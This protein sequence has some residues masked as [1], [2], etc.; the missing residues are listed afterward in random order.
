[1]QKLDV[2]E[3]KVI[4]FDFHNDPAKSGYYTFLIGKQRDEAFIVLLTCG[5]EVSAAA[6]AAQ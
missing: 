5:F 3:F 1:M 6:G 4:Q 2:K